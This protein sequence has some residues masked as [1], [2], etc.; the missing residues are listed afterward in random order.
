MVA[1]VPEPWLF[2]VRSRLQPSL[3]D[4]NQNRAG[5][6]DVH[7][8]LLLEV[9]A[10]IDGAE[11][12]EDIIL[13]KQTAEPVVKETG[14]RR[15]VVAPVADENSLDHFFSVRALNSVLRGAANRL[16]ADAAF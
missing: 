9:L 8:D 2:A 1:V 3:A 16:S 13:S 15:G 5:L 6:G 4:Q 11:V 7:S 10:G 12:Q 14:H